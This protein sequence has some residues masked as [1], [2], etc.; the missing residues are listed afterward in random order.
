[1]V[2][3][4]KQIVNEFLT[5]YI[6]NELESHTHILDENIRLEYSTLG[7]ITGI[8]ALLNALKWKHAFD[9]A[10]ITTTNSMEYTSSN[11]QI[12][13]CMV[14]HLVSYEKNNEMYPLVFGGK[15]VF[16]IDLMKEKISE[17][18]FVLEYQAENT[19]YVKGLW[20]LAQDNRNYEPL[21]LFD[22]S[23]YYQMIKMCTKEKK[24]KENINLFFWCL[25]TAEIN[26]LENLIDS[27]FTIS[28]EQSIGNELFES[29][30][31]SLVSFIKKTNAYYSLNQ[32]S[33]CI[34]SIK[35]ED[36]KIIISAQR[37]TPHR[38]GTKKLNSLTKFHSFFDEDITIELNKEDLTL[39]K[40]IMKRA[41]DVHYNGFE[42]LEF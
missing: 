33:I 9:V 42:I 14:H 40:I 10:H 27:T 2:T 25:D 8:D 3:T 26:I 36:F 11:H 34:S 28:R 32:N 7:S 39:H 35:D 15:Y 24:I 37:L 38:L 5:A 31:S 29:D 20:K 1:M 30:T 6:K 17:I 12:L 4:A 18:R 19:V 13:A 23:Y 41:A 16:E 21:S 22:T